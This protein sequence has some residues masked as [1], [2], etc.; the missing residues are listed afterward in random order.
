M[1]IIQI[2]PFS[3][4]EDFIDY[5]PMTLQHNGNNIFIDSFEDRL[6]TLFVSGKPHK[7]KQYRYFK[8]NSEQYTHIVLNDI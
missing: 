4:K 6:L 5:V 8:R 3:I 1:I 2:K 7:S